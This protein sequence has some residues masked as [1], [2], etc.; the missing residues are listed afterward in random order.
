MSRIKA[1][2][3]IGG[4]HGGGSERQVV[5]LL[6][7]ID[8]DRIEPIL[9]LVYRTGPLL[10]EI[11]SDIPVHAFD[12]RWTG[13]RWPGIL[14]HRR[15]VKDMK[16]FFAEVGA[17]VSYDRTFLM[18]LIAADA[19]Q[20]A[21]I[22][23][24]STIVTDP[25]VGFGT[26][27]GRF[28]NIKRRILGRLYR[29]SFRVLANSNG[30]ARSAESFYDLPPNFVQTHYNGVDI[31]RV[32]RIAASPVDDVWWNAAPTQKRRRFRIVTAGRLNE[33]K[34]FHFLI[35][36]VQT[37]QKQY[38][39]IDFRLAI[40]GEGPGRDQLSAQ[41]E[42]GKL[43]QRVQLKGFRHDAAAWFGSADLF[44]LPS[45]LEGMPNV[46]LEAIASGTAV[47]STDCRSGP[48][49]ILNGGELGALC[50]VGSSKALVAGISRFVDDPELANRYNAVAA[51]RIEQ[52]F[53]IQT[54]A[55]QL[56]ELLIDAVSSGT[57]GA[58]G[59]QQ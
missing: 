33:K 56:E 58:V 2:F 42:A 46:I 50:D 41:I 4:M 44:V 17:D 25:P 9:Y 39:D 16:D 23:N 1:V 7:H 15:R 28:Q 18:T 48:A 13:R 38:D 10:S 24:I 59:R 30:A 51:D 32:R 3:S 43:S 40:L 47:L 29:K 19:V 26:V 55:R 20:Q 35:E 34:G 5:S 53:S 12:E 37:L 54:A 27:A 22:P 57:H 11:P 6:Q 21:G 45:L 49:E 14:M 8:R 52:T 36:A 31:D